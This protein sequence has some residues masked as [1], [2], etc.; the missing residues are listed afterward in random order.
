LVHAVKKRFFMFGLLWTI[1][2]INLRESKYHFLQGFN[3]LSFLLY[4]TLILPYFLIPYL[5]LLF[6]FHFFCLERNYHSVL[7]FYQMGLLFAHFVMS[8]SVKCLFII[9]CVKHLIILVISFLCCKWSLTF[10]IKALTSFFCH[11]KTFLSRLL[12]I[13]KLLSDLLLNHIDVHFCYLIYW[14]APVS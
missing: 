8:R 10:D 7:K 1:L 5:H 9:L 3:F 4:F 14:W 2:S 11:I 6:H 13:C 12:N